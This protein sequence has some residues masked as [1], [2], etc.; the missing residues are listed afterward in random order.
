MK[1]SFAPLLTALLLML[2]T[3]CASVTPG[4]KVTYY[5]VDMICRAAHEIGCGSLAKPLLVEFEQSDAVEEAWLDRRGVVVALAW[6]AGTS[7]TEQERLTKT[8]FD[9]HHL[10]AEPV[11]DKERAELEKTFRKEGEWFRGKQVDELS[12]EEAGVIADRIMGWLG[13]GGEVP[14]SVAKPLREE[15]RQLFED[16]F[17]A[18]TGIQELDDAARDELHQNVN[19]AVV[20]SL[21][22]E[23]AQKIRIIYEERGISDPEM[24]NCCKNKSK[25]CKTDEHKVP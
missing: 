10:T 23:R 14:D 8:L 21:G 13:E 22:E 18:I 9:E 24:E 20:R 2:L 7:T 25:A 16:K 17:V 11:T 19:A 4:E 15:I 1:R 6:K 12:K 3:A 5:H